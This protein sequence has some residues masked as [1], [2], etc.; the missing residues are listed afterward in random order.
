[1]SDSEHYENSVE[2]IAVIGMSGRFPGAK[3]PDEFWQNLRD[4]VESIVSFTDE[5][6]TAS[7][8]DPELLKNPKYV[9]R[10]ATLS[11]IEM[12]DAAF[13]G[14]SPKE[15]ELTDPQHRLLLECAWEAIEAAGY[16]PEIYE[17]RIAVFAGIGI[18]TYLLRNLMSDPEF[19]NS[20]DVYQMSIG[21]DKD[22][23]ATRISYK[24]NLKGPSISV[25]TAC[26]TS[27]VAVQLACQS[28][29]TYQSDMALAGGATIQVPQK[30][31][32]LYQEGGIPS[33]DGYC[34]AFDA[35]AKGTVTSSGV[36]VVLLKRLEDA[37]AD[38]DCIHAVIRGAAINNDGSMKVGYTAPS[39]E[40][41]A[42]VIAEAQSLAGIS[43]ETIS[44]IEAHGTGTPLGDPIEIEALTQAFRAGTQKKGFC[45]I[46][47]VKTNIGHTDT[48]AGVAGLIKTVLALKHRMIPPNLHFE[49]P[50]PQIAFENSPFYVNAKLAEWHTE[51]GIPRRAGVSSFGIGGT[52]AH[53]VLEEVRGEGSGVRG[54]GS[55]D[56][57]RHPA[58]R[59]PNPEPHILVLSAKTESAL[60]TMTANLADY[61]KQHPDLNLA[62]AAYTL[63]VGRKAF[64]HRRIVICKDMADAEMTLRTRDPKKVFTSVQESQDRPLIF[65]FSGQGA[66]YVNMGLELYET[67]PTFRDT[68]DRCAEILRPLMGLDIREMIYP[69]GYRVRGTGNLSP[70]T[71]H[72]EPLS[73]DPE[74]LTRTSFTQP[75]LF[76]IEYALA[77]LWES[78]GIR[79]SAMIGHSIGE[80]V[81]ACLA[82]VFSLEDALSLVADRGSMMGELPG[83]AMLAVP[84]PEKE[85]RSL[86]NP[87]LSLA[88]VNGHSL[89]VVSGETET[90]NAFQQQLSQQGIVCQN[91]HTS[92]AFHSEMMTPV[93]KPFAERVRQIRLNPPQSPYISN[94]TG[95][96]ISAQDATDP[97]YWARHLRQTV[98]FADGIR[99]LLNNPAHIFLEIGPGR[100]LS[101][102]VM[103]HSD[104]KPEQPVLASLRHPKDSGSDRAF[105]L[106][107]LGRLWLAGANPDWVGFYSY[108][109]PHRVMLPTYPF[110]RKRFWW[111]QGYLS[112]LTPDPEPPE[113]KAD[114]ADWFYV[115]SWKRVPV[116][117]PFSKGG[118]G[119]FLLFLDDCGVGEALADRLKAEGQKCVTVKIGSE[120]AKLNEGEYVFNPGQYSDYNVLIRELRNSGNIPRT[121]VHLW[122]VTEN[123]QT[124]SGLEHLDKATDAGF[125]S[126][127]FLAQAIGKQNI[128][129]PIELTVISNHLHEVIG[130]EMLCPEKAT[131]LGPVKIIPQEYPNI[132]CSS[133]DIEHPPAPPSRGEL[134]LTGML[135]TEIMAKSSEPVVA[136][137]GNHRWVQSFEP[138]RLEPGDSQSKNR[139]KERGVYLITGGL[140]GIGF[141][142]AE[143]LAKTVHA[144]LILIGRSAFPVRDSW[145]QWLADHEEK[146]S[147]SLKILKIKKLEAMGAEVL[148]FSADVSDEEQMREVILLAEKRL[149]QIN[150][151]IHT[152]GLADYEGVIQR[153]TK[154]ATARILAPKV[155]GTLVLDK[156]LKNVRPDFFLLCSSLGNILYKRNF[157]QV[158]YNAANE[159]LDAFASY[160]NYRNSTFTVSVNWNW[161]GWQ[162]VDISVETTKQRTGRLHTGSEMNEESLTHLEAFFKNSILPS[163]GTEIFNCILEARQPRVAVSSQDLTMLFKQDIVGVTPLP[164]QSDKSIRSEPLIERPGLS[165]IYV[166]PRNETEQVLADIW[167]NLLGVRPIGI[168]D[169]FFELGGHSLI[170]VQLLS[171]VLDDFQIEL[172]LQ[173]VFD[174]PTIAELTEIIEMRRQSLQYDMDNILDVLEIVEQIPEEE[175]KGILEKKV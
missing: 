30:K 20:P 164:E 81:A 101:S 27:L 156:L 127:V 126:L 149:G 116:Y 23:A 112:P 68:V 58:P 45:A 144:K 26:S 111:G 147:I 66:Q 54:Q 25:N 74:P 51:A 91:L 102:F 135:L 5:E 140:G 132:T 108:H 130:G 93:I 67:E 173:T 115:P 33:P 84:L 96:W 153:R 95:T 168:H 69:A 152:A 64:S 7:G 9:R 36:G 31:G 82:G 114:I 56:E 76:V 98:R 62:D 171:R 146:D 12:F 44:Y 139:L 122:S 46:G 119:G 42:S 63:Q 34:R 89:C 123:T 40:G 80:Y 72:L 136:L 55:E 39:V 109:K 158:A 100:T 60:E 138:I 86:L 32:Y 121:I 24:L 29:L 172:S 117:S 35:K 15:A 104:K 19:I 59:T 118:Q 11:D 88:A 124:R 166:A 107:T 71:S 38:G 141:V 75:A 22:F 94:V 92:H 150:G 143:H 170:G 90:L 47:S 174:T 43:P 41:Q 28:L 129:D 155:K 2:P 17:G 6:L 53:V 169:N 120:F 1:M 49:T 37:I 13:F 87:G 157:G 16:N 14:F 167:Q 162:E 103:R 154:E 61:L 57:T 85:I 160:K 142:L 165:N 110:E 70:L 128:T 78:W 52:N 18:N 148:V 50:N 106:T 79:P 73:S 163:E 10:G 21:N 99:N 151:L 159:F 175:L 8:I 145:D 105:I 65:M 131:I 125:S 4:G 83:G 97:D 77:K 113:R 161:N 134:K 137:R 48:A 133:V 3:N